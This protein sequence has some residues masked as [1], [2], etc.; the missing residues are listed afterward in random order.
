MAL[1]I[2]LMPNISQATEVS[3]ATLDKI[4]ARLDRLEAENAALK[5]QVAGSRGN[6]VVG[7]K[8]V[9]T[10]IAHIT[11][12]AYVAPHSDEQLA[13]PGIEPVKSSPLND[14]S[15]SFVGAYGGLNV[16]YAWG[17]NNSARTES[18]PLYDRTNTQF[19]YSS[20]APTVITSP[21]QLGVSSFSNIG[22]ASLNQSGILGGIQVGYNLLIMPNIRAGIESDIQGSSLSG[23]ANYFGY[24]TNQRLVA[25]F[26]NGSSVTNLDASYKYLGGGN[27]SAGVNW[28]GTTR[29]RLGYM[30]ASN[31]LLYISGGFSY[32]GIYANN[33]NNLT[34]ENVV[35][36]SSSS[37]TLISSDVV[38]SSGGNGR[39]SGTRFGYSTGGGIEW[40]FSQNLGFKAEAIYYNLGSVSFA[41]NPVSI[42]G[43]TVGAAGI[44]GNIP[45]TRITYD[46]IIGR[47]GINYHFNLQ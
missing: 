11:Q 28:I 18:Y 13:Y 7:N 39:F 33:Q 47:T 37:F 26:S 34:Q 31:L 23:D 36:Q 2:S 30:P 10:P 19:G 16:G 32:G 6:K 22:T 8:I 3:A 1:A 40:M 9:S 12:P 41:A 24:P 25:N 20:I 4:M 15:N 5:R 35:T 27:I 42:G 21:A 44:I 14:I 38:S 46:G 29:A 17:L 43:L 45:V